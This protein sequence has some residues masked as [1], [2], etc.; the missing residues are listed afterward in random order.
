MQDSFKKTVVIEKRSAAAAIWG[1]GGRQGCLDSPAAFKAFTRQE[2][3]KWT[4]VSKQ[5]GAKVQ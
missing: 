5:V 4:A 1:G 2:T 3:E